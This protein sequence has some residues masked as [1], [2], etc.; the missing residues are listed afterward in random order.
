MVFFAGRFLTIRA[1]R[2]FHFIARTMRSLDSHVR[3]YSD[4][5]FHA[6][7]AFTYDSSIAIATY[8]PTNVP[9]N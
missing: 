3:G 1:A 6:M 9:G 4:P 2:A 5:Y 7:I 8:I